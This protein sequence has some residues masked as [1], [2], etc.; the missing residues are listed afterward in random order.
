MDT[1]EGDIITIIDSSGIERTRVVFDIKEDSVRYATIKKYRKWKRDFK[2]VY[3]QTTS[4]YKLT[5]RNIN[6]Q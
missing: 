3:V 4:D 5:G 2:L 1:K 6:D